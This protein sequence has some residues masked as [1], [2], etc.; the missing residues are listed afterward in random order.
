MSMLQPSL[1]ST[2]KTLPSQSS[3]ALVVAARPGVPAL[4]KQQSASMTLKGVRSKA[5]KTNPDGVGP[6]RSQE[7]WQVP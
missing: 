5:S 6:P 4:W 2:M 1:I 7:V 3:R